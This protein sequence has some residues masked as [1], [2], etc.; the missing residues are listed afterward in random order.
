MKLNNKTTAIFLAV[1]AAALYAISTP[2]SKVMLQ[3]APPTMVAVLIP[4]PIFLKEG[5][6]VFP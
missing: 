6:K 3:V 5:G 2:I 1:L 4:Y